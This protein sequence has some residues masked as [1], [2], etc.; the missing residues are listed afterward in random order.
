MID[1]EIDI[2]D[3][4]ARI[5]YAGWPTAYVTGEYVERPASF[6]CVTIIETVNQE[7]T[8]RRDSSGEEKAALL[9]YVVNVYSNSVTEAKQQ[10][11]AIMSA[12]DDRFRFYNF[13]RAFVRPVNNASD[14]T[15]YRL[16]GR[17]NGVLSN[18]GIHYGRRYE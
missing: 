1:Y 14:P 5:V 13:A 17:W 7:D 16:V 8:S 2:F 9:S 3:E 15:V 10:C 11:R 6:P 18:D 12:L 4:M